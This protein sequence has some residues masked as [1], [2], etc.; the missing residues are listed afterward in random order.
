V[1][2][3]FDPENPRHLKRSEVGERAGVVGSAMSNALVTAP[4][5]LRHVRPRE[6]NRRSCHKGSWVEPT[7]CAADACHMTFQ[8]IIT[9]T[10]KVQSMGR[11]AAAFRPVAAWVQTLKWFKFRGARRRLAAAEQPRVGSVLEPVRPKTAGR[12]L[13]DLISRAVTG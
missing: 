8:E 13:Q 1:K 6:G 5:L 7:G 11:Y 10:I 9:V 2:C 3:A 12:V 4:L